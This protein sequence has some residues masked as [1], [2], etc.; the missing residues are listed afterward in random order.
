[1]PEFNCRVANATGEIIQRTYSAESEAALRRELEGDELLVLDL[2]QKNPLLQKLAFRPRIAPREFLFFNQELAALIRAGLPILGSLDILIERRKNERFKRA[3]LDIRNRVKSGESLSEAFAAQG[4]MF[5]KLYAASLAS[6]ER[7]GELSSVLQRYITYSKKVLEVRRKV[8]AAMIYPVILLTLSV[9]IIC[10]L[11][12][13]VIP[14]FNQFLET[15]GAE[16]PMITQ[17]LVAIAL[18]CQNHWR[19]ILLIAVGAVVGLLLWQRTESGRIVL[20]R[21][22]LGLPLL[23][24]VISDSAQNRFTRTLATLQSGGIPL[25]TSL[26]LS[27]RAVGNRLFETELLKVTERV[28]EGQALWESLEQA[29]LMS[30]ITIEMVKVGESTGALDEMLESASDF[31]DEEIDH[32]L[33]RIVALIEP[34]ML[35]FMAVVVGIMLASIYLPLI[36]AVGGRT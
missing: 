29:D 32:R 35:I 36:T 9:A 16:L 14:R 34:I 2:R 19:Q 3:L 20:D 28:R 5:P 11:V 26:D 17:V 21:V 10:V 7:S 18:F 6:G 15:V 22:K 31:T 4:E 13:Y 8:S 24:R 23:G 33:T 25:V 30:D 1:M 27:A 12:F